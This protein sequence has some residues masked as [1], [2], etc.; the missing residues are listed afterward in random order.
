[1]K[2]D[3]ERPFQIVYSLFEHEYLGYLLESYV[4]QLDEKGRLSYSSQ[5]ISSQNAKEFTSGLDE[6]DYQL[7]EL[8]GQIQQDEILKKFNTKKLDPIKFFR[9]AFD[10]EKGN[11]EVRDYMTGYLDR[12]K[13]QI[14]ELIRVHNKRIFEMGHDGIVTWKE[15][16]IPT[17]PVSVRFNFFKNEDNTH[18]FPTLMHEKKKLNYQYKGAILVCTEPAY[19]LLGEHIYWFKE[20]LDGKKLKPFFNKKFVVVPKKVESTYY[21]KFIA[22][23]VANHHVF[24]KGFDIH[25]SEAPPQPVLEYSSIGAEQQLQI[26]NTEAEE[27][28]QKSATKLQIR[29][30]FNYDGRLFQEIGQHAYSVSFEEPQEREYVFHKIKRQQEYEKDLQKRLKETGL[31]IIKGKATWSFNKAA[32]WMTRHQ[33]W[34]EEEGIQL[35]ECTNGGAKQNGGTHTIFTGERKMELFVQESEDWFDIKAKVQFGPY[36]VSFME[37]RNLILNGEEMIKLPNGQWAALDPQW[38][39][40]YQDLFG[41]A[42]TDK[43]QENAE[44]Q[45]KLKKHH[46]ALV[47]ILQEKKLAKVNI[48]S[49]LKGLQDFEKIEDYPLPA[50]FKGTLRPYQKAG[51]NWMQFLRKFHFGGCLA[52]DM[53]LGKTIQTL[54]VLQHEKEHQGGTSLLIMPTSLVYNWQ[55]EA[56]KFTPELKV[57]PFVGTQRNKKIENFANYDIVITSYGTARIDADILKEFYFNYIILD[58][59]QIIKNPNSNTA[60]ALNQL[61]SRHRLILTGTPLENTT[62]DL[63][64]QINFVNPGLLGTKGYFKKYFLKEIEKKGN[65]HKIERLHAMLKPFILRRHK[66]QV[67]R[68]L[69]DKVEQIQYCGMTE[70]QEQTYEE[71]KNYFRNTFLEEV[72]KNGLKQS[73]FLLFQGLAKL[74]QIAN[75]PRMTDPQFEGDSGKLEEVKE[76][77]HR[78]LE[79]GHKIL[80]FSQFVKHLS[81]LRKVLKAEGI[82]YNYLDGSTKDRQEQVEHFQNEESTRVFLI[83]LK[84]GGVGLNL[85]AADY[86]FLLDPWFNPAVEQQAIDRTHRIGQTKNVFIY[87]F[88][89]RDTV[90]EKILKLQ[91]RKKQLADELISS[92]ESFMKS[93]VQDDIMNILN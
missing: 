84:A 8:T 91:E 25:S 54:A 50:G 93:L 9:M 11:K 82:S 59:S 23:L 70:E 2:V 57:F 7:I 24:A 27:K 65:T 64:S 58:E 26:G 12:K 60:K 69:P 89:T 31:P 75:H 37:I 6:V 49:K 44:E 17:E 87:R 41:F 36:E 45:L 46:I 3:T 22:P 61:K 21:Q 71:T 4:V 66:Q 14:L 18:Y 13:A 85:T 77:L 53:G 68:D 83:S 79:E 38:M 1:M 30:K 88:I 51:Y 81:I 32:N 62:M 92:E 67:A 29:L 5:N 42:E 74:R 73:R 52:D 35:Q 48:R 86:V 20:K 90:E 28:T 76:K 43:N 34:L 16:S 10:K 15:L 72:E 56:S 33:E 55:L 19:M 63:W 40:E 39:D 47:K 78:L 80:I